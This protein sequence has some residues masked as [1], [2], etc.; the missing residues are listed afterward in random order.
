M[1]REGRHFSDQLKSPEAKE[2][3]AAF[4][5]KRKPDFSKVGHR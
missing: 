1:D 3:F 4:A 2:A 5:E